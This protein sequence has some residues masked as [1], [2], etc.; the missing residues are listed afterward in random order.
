MVRALAVLVSQ[1]R[2]RLG[3]RQDRNGQVLPVGRREVGGV[4]RFL[5]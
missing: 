5:G 4:C 3:A 1:A 2:H